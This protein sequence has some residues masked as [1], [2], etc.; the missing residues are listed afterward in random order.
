MEIAPRGE[1]EKKKTRL[2]IASFLITCSYGILVKHASYF[3]AMFVVSISSV[4]E[5]HHIEY[6]I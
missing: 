3:F 6:L 1:I 4:T 2:V 5:R